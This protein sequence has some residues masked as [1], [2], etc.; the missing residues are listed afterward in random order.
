LYPELTREALTAREAALE[1]FARWEAR[2]PAC[3]SASAAIAGV[4]ALY[5]LLPPESRRRPPDP[6]G[7]RAFHALMARLATGR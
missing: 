2:H 3:R 7:V 5:E 6:S 4:A 1:R